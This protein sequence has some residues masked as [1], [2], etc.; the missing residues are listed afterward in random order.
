MER[1]S[2]KQQDLRR[3]DHPGDEDTQPPGGDAERIRDV[4]VGGGEGTGAG[5]E[6]WLLGTRG[7]A[8]KRVSSH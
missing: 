6:S 1:I 8:R 4:P 7:G 2:H 3:E 5:P